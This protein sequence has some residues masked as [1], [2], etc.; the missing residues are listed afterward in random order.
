VGGR[1]IIHVIA[2][3]IVVPKQLLIVP[4]LLLFISPS[5]AL[6]M[7]AVFWAINKYMPILAHAFDTT[8][9]VV[10]SNIA[11]HGFWPL[12]VIGQFVM[13]VIHYPGWSASNPVGS[14]SGIEWSCFF[15]NLPSIVL[16]FCILYFIASFFAYVLIRGV[17][18]LTLSYVYGVVLAVSM[19]AIRLIRTLS[20]FFITAR[21]KSSRSSRSSTSSSSSAASSSLSSSSFIG[22]RLNDHE[23]VE[24]GQDL[25]VF[26]DS[27]RPQSQ[28]SG[29][30]V[31]RKRRKH[32]TDS[33]G[34]M[35]D[36]TDQPSRLTPRKKGQRKRKS[37]GLL[38][39]L[40]ESSSSSSSSSSSKTTTVMGRS[41]DEKGAALSIINKR[42]R[43]A[44]P[45]KSTSD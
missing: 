24:K 1:F 32:K 39:S 4:F 35:M 28:H 44:R 17:V 18:T 5:K 41:A 15:V 13:N 31:L 11:D 9:V 3:G 6:V 26:D 8:I 10:A 25:I 37:G 45:F 34:L 30:N 38:S 42:K 7:A 23:D 33:K 40:F 29:S 27:F 36:E 43:R 2:Y 20:T 16:G 22:S 19:L 14:L 21:S 12:S